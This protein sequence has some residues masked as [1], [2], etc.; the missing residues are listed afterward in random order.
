MNK[1]QE[2]YMKVAAR[3]CEYRKK[4]KY[5]QQQMGTYLDVTQAHYSKLEAGTKIISRNSLIH[6][7]NNGGDVEWLITGREQKNGIFNQYFGRYSDERSKGAF[8]EMSLWII[9]QGLRIG[10]YS[11]G[12]CLKNA[13][14]TIRLLLL[15]DRE[16]SIWTGIR[17]TED[18]T[19]MQMA[20]ILDINIK[21]YRRLE[22][23][24]AEEDAAVLASLYV[25]LGYSPMLLLWKKIY[26]M[27][28]LNMVW[29][30]FDL[31][32]QERLLQYVIKMS[33]LI[34]D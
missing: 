5:T 4:M 11:D 7:H 3:L 6:F 25:N 29:D 26:C 32:L 21:R 15:K 12:D 14:K 30:K 19:Q 27:S 10:H 9:E 1:N 20:D 23:G 33:E 13:N 28:E 31:Q 24:L 2:A 22:K 18:M 16:C 34:S 8:L 17:E